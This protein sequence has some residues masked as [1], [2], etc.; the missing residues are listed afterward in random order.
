ML[1]KFTCFYFVE[2]SMF[3]FE[4]NYIVLKCYS[5]KFYF[6]AVYQLKVLNG[7]YKHETCPEHLRNI[8]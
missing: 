8:K 7:S 1:P 3:L 2:I 6:L 5:N 4:L